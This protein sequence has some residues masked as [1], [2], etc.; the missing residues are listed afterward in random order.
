MTLLPPHRGKHPSAGLSPQ[1][2]SDTGVSQSRVSPRGQTGSQGTPSPPA[3]GHERREEGRGG[4]EGEEESRGAQGP[5]RG[6]P[7]TSSFSRTPLS[8][9]SRS[10]PLR[11][12]DTES[13]GTRAIPMPST[14]LQG[15][16][17]S[18]TKGGSR[19]EYH[20]HEFPR[21]AMENGAFG[22]AAWIIKALIQT[23]V[24]LRAPGS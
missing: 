1:S 18:L 21:P 2:Y 11:L 19:K 5:E 6:L 8:G 10:D 15:S 24:C 7:S 12:G 17:S 14:G 23:P 3:L 16:A 4:G 13:P 20:M 9:S 22:K